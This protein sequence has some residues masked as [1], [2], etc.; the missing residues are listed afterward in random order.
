[1]K[2]TEID[3]RDVSGIGLV[4]GAIVAYLLAVIYSENGA[5]YNINM[6]ITLACLVLLTIFWQKFRWAVLYASPLLVAVILAAFFS[7]TVYA[8]AIKTLRAIKKIT[9]K[10]E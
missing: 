9:T 5:L 6:L 1:M 4:Y 8:P 7:L 3:W 10:G 2:I